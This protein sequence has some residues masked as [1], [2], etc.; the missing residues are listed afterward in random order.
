VRGRVRITG[1]T[2]MAFAGQAGAGR[3]RESNDDYILRDR[4]LFLI[5][6]GK[7][8]YKRANGFEPGRARQSA[9]FAEQ[10]ELRA[11]CRP[12]ARPTTRRVQASGTTAR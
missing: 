4:D 8:R 11:G 3:H 6:D 2:V 10:E 12:I 1:Y 5:C 7:G 9:T